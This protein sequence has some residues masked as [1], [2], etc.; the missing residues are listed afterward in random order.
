MTDITIPPDADEDQARRLIEDHVEIGDV[1][2]IRSEERTEDHP[3]DVTGEV[4]GIE[5]GYV[6]ID[7]RPVGEGS[8]RYDQIHTV[9]KIE[10]E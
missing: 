1:V 6:E 7:G 4:T 9:G 8:V 3:V 10:S 5:P 2:E